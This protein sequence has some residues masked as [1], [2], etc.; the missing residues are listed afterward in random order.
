MVIKNDNGLNIQTKHRPIGLRANLNQFVLLVIVNAFVG[1]M[2]GMERSI[3]PQIAISE[4]GLTAKSAVLSFI[5]AFG[6]T[7]AFANLMTGRIAARWGRKKLLLL[8]WILGLPVPFLLIY[9]PDWNWIIAANLLLGAHQGFAWSATVVMKIDLVGE[10]DRGLA[11][12][13]N[14]FAG[15]LAVALAA[16]A[17]GW[18]AGSY[19][20][21]PYPFYLGIGLSV[22]GLLATV[23]LVKDTHAH[24][25]AEAA[26]SNIPRLKRIFWDTTWGHKNLGSVSL[27]GLVNNLNDGMVWGLLPLMLAQ[28]S[29]SLSETGLLAAVYPA[30]WGVSQIFTGRLS[31][32]VCKKDLLM[33]GMILQGVALF[34]LSYSDV[35]SSFAVWLSLLGFGTALV[36]PT[37]LASIADNTH[38]HDRAHSLGIF[39]FWRDMGYAAGALLFGVLADY[40]GISFSFMGVGLITVLT[41]L[42]ANYRMRCK[43]S[44]PEL[45][46]WLRSGISRTGAKFRNGTRNFNSVIRV[47]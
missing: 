36:Y 19:G 2:V 3:L 11:M 27:T 23:F 38:P 40:A 30:V 45:W 16:L 18:I 42:G 25:A 13:L 24:V 22:A 26:V 15:Y 39:R 20:L 47:I 1:G 33:W 28:R 8:G 14:E 35:F 10:R 44:H 34:G 12:G 6:V 7:K 17:S 37:F 31:D 46:P 9:A 21:R 43:T 29:F 32:Y 5:V 41:G 4:F